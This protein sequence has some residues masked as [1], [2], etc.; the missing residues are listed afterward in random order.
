LRGKKKGK[1]AEKSKF[2]HRKEKKEKNI[3]ESTEK[4][5]FG[6]SPTQPRKRGRRFSRGARPLTQG[7][8]GKG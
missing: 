5:W 1:G 8:R 3:C 7:E 6:P 4:G 2:I